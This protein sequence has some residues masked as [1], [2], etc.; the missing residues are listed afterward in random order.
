MPKVG[1]KHS[2]A[3]LAKMLTSQR[4]RVTP[5]RER[6]YNAFEF[7]L[8]GGC[9]LWFGA[10]INGTGYGSISHNSKNI[11]A[12]RLS[13]EIHHG[14]IPDGLCVCH[15]CDVR[16]CVNPDH[17]FLGTHADN[18]HD[19][20]RKGRGGYLLGEENHSSKL[21]ARDIPIILDR[22]RQGQTCRQIGDSYGLTECAIN[23][24]RRGKSWRHITG[25]IKQGP[26]DER[27][28]A[29]D[30]EPITGGG[31]SDTSGENPTPGLHC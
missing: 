5:L 30:A 15:H 12:H 18:M 29:R 28:Q 10:M 22:L 24:I 6:F 26:P 20:D 3:S 23:A 11:A 9:W 17:L 4:R 2:E 27:T 19:K 21:K 31:G 8:N 14:P 7:D 16:A 25:F 13:W 1:F